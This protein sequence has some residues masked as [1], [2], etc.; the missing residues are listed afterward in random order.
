MLRS[1]TGFGEASTV[2]NG[3]QIRVEIRSVNNRHLKVS[4]RAED[5]LQCFEAELER[6]VRAALHRGTVQVS[7]ESI[8]PSRADVYKINQ[9]ALG[10]Y[11][12]QV[13]E[14]LGGPIPDSSIGTI[15]S[16]ILALPGV[17]SDQTHRGTESRSRD[18]DWAIIRPVLDEAIVR[19]G[20]M[21]QC[22]GANM[23]LELLSMSGHIR[24]LVAQVRLRIPLSLIQQQERLH[25]RVSQLLVL[26][27]PTVQVDVSHLAREIALL[28]DR[29]D[30]SEEMVRLESHLDQ[31]DTMMAAKSPAEGMGRKLEFLIQEMGREANTMGSKSPDVE[32]SRTV[33]EIKATMERI[34]EL[35][36]NVE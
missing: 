12:S 14:V 1:M 2:F 32:I 35:V 9:V 30:I 18:D 20:Q 24:G 26:H 4:L 31:F 10:A 15:V 25:Q 6:L 16:G 8:R 29:V 3:W 22:E 36:L 27:E 11:L 21:R 7:I 17:V 13:A 34:R 23:A 5:A 19:L 33:V 28:A